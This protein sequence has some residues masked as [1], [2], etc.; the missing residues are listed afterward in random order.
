MVSGRGSKSANINSWFPP[1]YV[2]I[3]DSWVISVRA[4]SDNVKT[5][6]IGEGLFETLF[7]QIINFYLYSNQ[8]WA[9]LLFLMDHRKFRDCFSSCL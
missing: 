8:T 6:Y 1:S 9:S 7:P 5:V 2:N 4:A 3:T